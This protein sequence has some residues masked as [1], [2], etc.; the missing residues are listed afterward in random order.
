M[1][2]SLYEQVNIPENVTYFVHLHDHIHV[3]VMFTCMFMYMYLYMNMKSAYS[4]A[5]LCTS[6]Y[7][8]SRSGM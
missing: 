7:S 1:C 8:C 5:V 2:K 6:S 3:P 4:R